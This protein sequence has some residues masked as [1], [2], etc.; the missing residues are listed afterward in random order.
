[1][2]KKKEI[3]KRDR[4]WMK[5]NEYEINNVFKRDFWI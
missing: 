4:W 3:R 5:R 2:F 1:M